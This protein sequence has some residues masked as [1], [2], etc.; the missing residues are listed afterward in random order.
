MMS[1]WNTLVGKLIRFL[2]TLFN[3]K[4]LDNLQLELANCAPTH[5]E[6]SN[7]Q[8]FSVHLIMNLRKTMRVD[9]D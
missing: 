1:V 8:I 4:R 3:L 6:D 9:A 2:R 7:A 5:G